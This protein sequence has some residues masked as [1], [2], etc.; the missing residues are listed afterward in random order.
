[1]SQP[2]QASFINRFHSS[3]R[4]ASHSI[5]YSLLDPQ[6]C[7]THSDH[8]TG[9]RSALYS[10]PN[11]LMREPGGLEGMRH[12][13]GVVVSS[14]RGGFELRDGKYLG[15]RRALGPIVRKVSDGDP[16]MLQGPCLL[17]PVCVRHEGLQGH[18]DECLVRIG[19]SDNV[20]PLDIQ[21]FPQVRWP[22]V[23]PKMGYMLS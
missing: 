19:L 3:S 20:V 15:T 8:Q 5:R 23:I 2:F 11:I 21:R 1:L 9:H 22:P 16:I 10:H 17:P 4:L 6:C 13:P 18:K 14:G 7:A 12:S